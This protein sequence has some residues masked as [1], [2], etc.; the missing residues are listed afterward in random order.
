VRRSW[1]LVVVG[2]G[3]LERLEFLLVSFG[4]VHFACGS[5][6]GP[7]V[8]DEFLSGFVDDFEPESALVHWASVADF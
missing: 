2:L 4:E 6:V 1:E 5:A 3:C 7:V 8:A